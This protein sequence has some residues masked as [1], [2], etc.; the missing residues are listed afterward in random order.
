MSSFA[1]EK[2]M[3][4]RAITTKPE[5]TTSTMEMMYRVVPSPGVSLGTVS[6]TMSGPDMMI[7]DT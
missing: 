4:I 7:G 6:G 5:T 2:T 1:L 3:A